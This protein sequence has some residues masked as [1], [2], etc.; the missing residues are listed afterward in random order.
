MRLP[1][2]IRPAAPQCYFLVPP[3]AESHGVPR[4]WAAPIPGYPRITPQN[5]E[6][7]WTTGN[8][9]NECISH[10]CTNFAIL[11]FCLAAGRV[12][13]LVH[14]PGRPQP[15][16]LPGTPAATGLLSYQQ[17]TTSDYIAAE[18]RLGQTAAGTHDRRS[19]AD[20]LYRT[21]RT[22]VSGFPPRHKSQCFAE[23]RSIVRGGGEPSGR[24]AQHIE[25][26]RPVL[27]SG[28]PGRPA[29]LPV[30]RCASPKAKAARC[31]KLR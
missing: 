1:I 8:R 12:S 29:T 4:N 16:L 26:P 2:L 22:G 31:R 24:S 14:C 13:S 17:T 28:T 7:P 25:S 11:W 10:T 9:E 19:T 21:L 30:V 27:P 18:R 20:L 23:G 15:P 6:S 3:V 5:T